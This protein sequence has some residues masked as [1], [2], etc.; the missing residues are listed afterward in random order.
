MVNNKCQHEFVESCPETLLE[1][2]ENLWT[3]D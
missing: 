2:D 1:T 3:Y